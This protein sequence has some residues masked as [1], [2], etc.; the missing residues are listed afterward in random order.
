MMRSESPRALASP[1]ARLARTGHEGI[2]TRSSD[3]RRE[4]TFHGWRGF[5]L[6]RWLANRL[7]EV[8]RT[9]ARASVGPMPPSR[10]AP[11]ARVP[12]VS[13]TRETTLYPPPPACS[14]RGVL[15][16]ES[17]SSTRR[18]AWPGGRGPGGCLRWDTS[19]M[20]AMQACRLVYPVETYRPVRW[21]HQEDTCTTKEPDC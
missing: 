10:R 6:Q 5:Y 19:G 18:A 4:D 12:G 9:S 16:T 15:A 1:L 14:V 13:A 20:S 17:R 7:A 3:Q 2:G 8:R 21:S 11:L